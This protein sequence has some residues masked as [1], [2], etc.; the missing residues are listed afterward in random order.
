M[1]PDCPLL[2]HSQ[3]ITP[4]PFLVCNLHEE[5]I[6]KGLSNGKVTLL[7][8]N[9][10]YEVNFKPLRCSFELEFADV[11]CLCKRPGGQLMIPAPRLVV[12]M[13]RAAVELRKTGLSLAIPTLNV[14]VVKFRSVKWTPSGTLRRAFAASASFHWVFGRSHTLGPV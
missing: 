13:L 9:G 2:V 4:L 10:G 5:T 14:V 8:I 7:V 6:A 3:I 11:V 1:S 12:L